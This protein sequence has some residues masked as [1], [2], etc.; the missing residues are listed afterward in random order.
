MPLD[1]AGC[2]ASPAVSVPGD[3]VDAVSVRMSEVLGALS[4]ALDLTEGQPPGHSL[5]C[6]WIGMHIGRAMGLDEAAL[7]DLYYALLLKD[8]GCSSNAARLWELYGGDERAVKHDFKTVDSHS[9]LQLGRFVLQHAGPGEALR[10]RIQRVL[11]I[12]RSGDEMARE[13][14]LARCDRGANICRRLGFGEAVAA[15]VYSLDEHWNGRGRGC[16]LAGDAIPINARIALLAQVVDV[17]HAVGGEQA[18]RAEVR[19]RAGSWFDPQVVAAFFDA[20]TDAAFWS[21]L[22]DAAPDLPSPDLPSPDLPSP[23]LPSLDARVAALEPVACVMLVDQ[24]RL[25]IVSAAFADIVDAKS[26]FTYSHSRRVMQYGD[27]VAAQMGVVPERRRWLR[28][29]SLLHDIGKVAVSNGILDKPGRLDASEFAVIKTHSAHSEVILQRIGIFRDLAPVA[30]AHHERLDGGGY[31]KG[32]KAPQIPLESRIITVADIFDA[33]TAARPYRGPMP[34]ADALAL[35]E[36]DRDTAIDSDCL[37]ALHR[38][39]PSMECAV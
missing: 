12:T 19:R 18:A 20:A 3:P 1:I 17:F 15:G 27:A 37:D 2:T 21:G 22:T 31:P 33:L 25:D 29:A 5:R 4:Y 9:M 38:A 28:R 13:L 6:C 34:P 10:S 16:G 26:S 36:R 7:S 39:L 11:A 35:M 30:G 14:V 23:G 32:L 24:D 8:A